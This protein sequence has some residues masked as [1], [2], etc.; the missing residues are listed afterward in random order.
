MATACLGLA[1]ASLAGLAAGLH[2]GDSVF[3][4]LAQ[5]L[6]VGAAGRAIVMSSTGSVCY[7]L[8]L[9][10][11]ACWGLLLGGGSMSSCNNMV[12][13]CVW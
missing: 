7:V 3:Q 4:Q 5:A 1:C 2:Q 10:I 13:L 9:L 6:N 11:R 12:R 8:L